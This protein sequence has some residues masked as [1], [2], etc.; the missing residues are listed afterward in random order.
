[1]G[2][3]ME[4]CVDKECPKVVVWMKEVEEKPLRGGQLGHR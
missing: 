4:T 3:N 2:G 1:M